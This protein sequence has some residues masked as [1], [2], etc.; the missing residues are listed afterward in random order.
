MLPVKV[1]FVPRPGLFIS[2]NL[3]LLLPPPPNILSTPHSLVII[4]LFS[5]SPS[6]KITIAKS[7]YLPPLT[8]TLL[9]HDQN[10]TLVVPGVHI[11]LDMLQKSPH[12]LVMA[13]GFEKYFWR[14][15]GG[16]LGTW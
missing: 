2:L 4:F 12:K 8:F 9:F 3:L 6:Y 15:F 11:S 5:T 1:Q 16:N 10:F 13:L 14:V 7:I